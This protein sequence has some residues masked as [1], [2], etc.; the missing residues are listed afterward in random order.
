MLPMVAA[1]TSCS[2]V[3]RKK[4]PK[5]N[6]IKSL[7]PSNPHYLR[8]VDM[9]GI[10]SQFSATI[11]KI[12]KYDEVICWIYQTCKNIHLLCAGQDGGEY[13]NRKILPVKVKR[14]MHC[15]RLK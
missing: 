12:P 11:W 14:G 4:D 7:S 2:V 3:I 6:V 1:E 13:N 10:V 5:F 15:T 8:L 9:V